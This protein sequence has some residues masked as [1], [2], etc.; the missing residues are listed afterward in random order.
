MRCD[1]C[2]LQSAE[3]SSLPVADAVARLAR[4]DECPILH[5]GEPCPSD[6]TNVLVSKLRESSMEAR[7]QAN[8]LRRAEHARS[9]LTA[10]IERSDARVAKI[11]A[12]HAQSTREVEA[13]L[14]AK[15]DLV[16]E[17]RV[18][19]QSLSTPIIQVSDA[20]LVVPL[21]GD[22]DSRRAE[23][24]TSR[25]LAS[26]RDRRARYAILELT[27]ISSL[28]A[29]SIDQLIMVVRAVG[30]LGASVVVCGVRPEVARLLSAMHIDL[31]QLR[32]ASSLREALLLC[33]SEI[34]R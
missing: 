9:E 16:E 7:R 8:K 34:H 24:L 30:L 29:A 17:Q 14:R 6:V 27:G 2:V 28:D 32:A 23:D 1:R 33:R 22:I 3:L 4:C 19:I 5:G 26:I 20:V 15:I 12:L 10:E 31:S 25:L 21:I 11:E 18:A 13:E